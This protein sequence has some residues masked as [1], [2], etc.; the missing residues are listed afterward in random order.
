M[1]KRHAREFGQ[2][3]RVGKALHLVE[4][5]YDE[6]AVHIGMGGTYW[7]H[8]A[9]HRIQEGKEPVVKLDGGGDNMPDDLGRIEVAVRMLYSKTASEPL[10]GDSRRQRDVAIESIDR[11]R[12]A[13]KEAQMDR[14]TQQQVEEFQSSLEY[15]SLKVAT[16]YLSEAFVSGGHDEVRQLRDKVES[17]MRTRLGVDN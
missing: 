6:V 12:T 15:D 8:S 14:T 3:N 7:L 11:L 5:G 4:H 16:Q 9:A 17:Y 10:N 2:A 1:D 13:L